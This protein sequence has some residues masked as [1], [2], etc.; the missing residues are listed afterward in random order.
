M[1]IKC[2]ECKTVHNI[3]EAKI[4]EKG[5]YA[6][7]KKC[8]HRFLVKKQSITHK[9]KA[10]EREKTKQ[11]KAK[12]SHSNKKK[13]KQ[14]PTQNKKKTG[15]GASPKPLSS[16]IPNTSDSFVN[17][18]QILNISQNASTEDIKKD[19]NH[20]LRVWSNRTNSPSLE[21]RQEAERMVKVIEEA[22]KIL[23]DPEKRKEYDRKLQTEYHSEQIVDEDD[24]HEEDDLVKEGWNLLIMGNIPDAIYV[25]TKA[26][27]Q[28][29]KNP[30]AW[31]LLAQAKF[32]WGETEDAIYEYKSA[33]RLKP[34][35]SSYYFDLGT[36]YESI[37]RWGDALQQYQR[38]AQIDPNITMYKAATGALF[39]RTENYKE[40]I[41]ILEQCVKEESQNEIYQWYLAIAYHDGMISSW[42]K[43][44][45]DG[46]FY[47]INKV[48][49]DN[50]IT[51]IKRAKELEYDDNKLKAQINDTEKHVLSM[52][53]R[54]FMGSWIMVIILGLC[55]VVP[56]LVWWFVN[57]RP[58]YKINRDIYDLI[59][60]G[61]TELLVEGEAG[62]YY[63]ALP[64]GLKWAAYS[65][66]RFVVWC[67]I[68]GF[69]PFNCLYLLYDNYIAE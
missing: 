69:S 5:A 22:E 56:G 10:V 20:E 26:T 40:G 31:A 3:N 50:S 67:L 1:K 38:A 16:R 49:L 66:P 6:R 33:I 68:I 13:P 62:F 59:E 11:S 53:E 30:E 4:P 36:V 8:N 64:P 7:C 46:K 52:E 19:I 34:N 55:Y 9:P 65:L 2:P 35:E 15:R 27:E 54:E 42:W 44:P 18:Y 39:V 28:Q 61:K 51:M 23:L 45:N 57:R 21:R 41:E 14:T 63:S 60:L 58:R 43:N 37:E 47:C 12:T 48:Q 32:R 24:I 25:A 29:A 17:F